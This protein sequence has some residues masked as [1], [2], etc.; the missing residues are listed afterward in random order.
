MFL[1]VPPAKKGM[2]FLKKFFTRQENKFSHLKN[3]LPLRLAKP[4]YYLLTIKM[5]APPVSLEPDPE[6]VEFFTRNAGR[7]EAV[8]S[9]LADEQSKQTFR[10]CCRFRQTRDRRDCPRY[11][12]RLQ[13]FSAFRFQPGEVFVDCG[14]FTG[15][16]MDDFIRHCPRYKQIVAFEP[17]AK[18]FALLQTKHG[19]TRGATLVNSGVYDREVETFFAGYGVGGKITENHRAGAAGIRTSTID[20]LGLDKITFIKMDI[21]GGELDALKGAEKTI[22]RDTPKLAVCIYHSH[23]DMLRIAEYLHAL[24]PKYRLR[25]KHHHCY[26][27]CLETV[28]YANIP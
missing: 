2:V 7:V 25:V 11:D 10:Q 13:Y 21:E 19:A 15:D 5:G 17:D 18:N 24:V 20:S 8:A 26:P 27:F 28:L 22:L 23:E 16:S 4:W 14:A 1:F 12:W 6:A 9:L 3:C